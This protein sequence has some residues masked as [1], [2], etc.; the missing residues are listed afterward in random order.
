[1]S[2]I[3]WKCPIAS[4]EHIHAGG[5][6]YVADYFDEESLRRDVMEIND[7][8]EPVC[9][10][11][12]CDKNGKRL[13]PPL[14]WMGEINCFSIFVRDEPAPPVQDKNSRYEIYQIQR[15]DNIPYLFLRYE[16]AKDK[17]T[18]KDYDRVYAAPLVPGITL[19]DLY[20][21][22]NED[23]R[24]AAHT[25]HSLSISDVIVVRGGKQSRAFYV[26]SI[27]FQ[28]IPQFV[29]ELEQLK[30]EQ[31]QSCHS[32]IQHEER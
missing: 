13:A 12:Y 20:I 17:I 14:A 24:P 8:G 9:V 10:I 19:D 11:L 16:S 23:D 15:R 28:E 32:V 3:R 5:V 2:D 26:D 25:M 1:M 6:G 18:A 31:R 7:S 27:G 30:Q 4:I 21:S 29:R 22:H